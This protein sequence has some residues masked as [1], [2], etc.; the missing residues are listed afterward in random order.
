MQHWHCH[1]DDV[2]LS[3]REFSITKKMKGYRDRCAAVE[4]QPMRIEVFLPIRG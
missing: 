1:D 4:G 3:V 2:L